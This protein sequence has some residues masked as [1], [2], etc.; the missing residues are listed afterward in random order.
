MVIM[1]YNIRGGWG[2]DNIRSLTRIADVIRRSGAHI[3]CLQEV[4]K[5]WPKSQFKDQP[6]WLG[7]RL[8]ME[9]VFQ[10]NLSIGPSGFGNLILTRFPIT[11]VKSHALTSVGEQRGVLEVKVI[12]PE[13]PVT[14]FCTHWGLNSD[15]RVV[16][17]VE[18]SSYIAASSTPAVLCGD[19]N[20]IDTSPSV[21]RLI[22]SGLHDLAAGLC[23]T[24]ATFPSDMPKC[25]IDFILGT[26]NIK[27]A[28]AVVIESP[29]SDH[30]PVVVEAFLQS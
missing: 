19:L 10:P 21:S 20:D 2:I 13:G 6:R 22:S 5:R 18:T 15:E 16:Q 29:A 14:I 8:G 1:T 28:T 11:F 9:F 25:R 3:A 26:S 24:D 30:R 4:G 27:A 23:V 7:Q 17:S 12:S